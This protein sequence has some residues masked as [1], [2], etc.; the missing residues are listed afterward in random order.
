M[1]VGAIVAITLGS[2]NSW[3]VAITEN[4]PVS[5]SAGRIEGSLTCHAIRHADAPST[6]AAS[7]SSGGTVRNAAN[8]MIM[9]YPMYS[10]LTM[11]AS[12]PSI[13][14]LVRNLGFGRPT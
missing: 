1:T 9:L 12:E 13:H 4:S 6:A 10:Q 14:V 7:Y 5:N 2:L 11:L 3:K 8:R